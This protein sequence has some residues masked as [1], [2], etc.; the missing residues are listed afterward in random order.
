MMAHLVGANS[1]PS[2]ATFCLYETARQFGKFFN[3]NIT[4]SVLENFYVDDYLTEAKSKKAAV[5]LV[6]NLRSLHAMDGFKLKKWL[7]SNKKV[8]LS[9]PAEDK[10]KAHRND[11]PSCGPSERVL[12]ICWNVTSD[13]FFFTTDVPD[14]SFTKRK[15]LANT[16]FLYDSLGFV[17]S[18]VLLAIL[19]HSEICTQ[20]HSWDAS[21]EGNLKTG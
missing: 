21:I 2:C 14:T 8:M 17:S 3:S 10:S 13:E 20:Q 18:V 11:M 7:S 1:S 12:N 4:R 19:L 9:I 6:K 15:V 5:N 16:N